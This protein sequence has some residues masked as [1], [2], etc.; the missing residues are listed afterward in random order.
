MA[1]CNI[2]IK[3][4]LNHSYHLNCDICKGM[5]KQK[6]P[7]FY[8]QGRK[9]ICCSLC[10][11]DIFAYNRLDDEDFIDALAESWENQPL[12]S[13]ETLE[14]QELIFSPFDFNDNFDTPLHDVDPDMQ[15]Y[16]KHYFGSLQECDYCLENMFNEKIKKCKI[17][18]QSFSVLHMNIRSMQKNLGSPENCLEAL[19]H[20][21]TAIGISESWLK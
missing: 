15:F 8:T 1:I 21:F 10:L 14:N 7:T 2:C 9:N 3:R 13:F 19:D 12:I 18:S 17:S 20:K 5:C 11:L 16:N 6:W 4:V